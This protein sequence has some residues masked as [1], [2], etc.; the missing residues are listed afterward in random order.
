[1]L[2]DMLKRTG[3][4]HPCGSRAEA[5]GHAAG[6]VGQRGQR[7]G[8]RGKSGGGPASCDPTASW[9]WP[10]RGRDGTLTVIRDLNMKE[11]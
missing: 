9:T 7:P 8:H 1:M 11:P 3:P 10:G 2:G 5:P 6:G 4:P